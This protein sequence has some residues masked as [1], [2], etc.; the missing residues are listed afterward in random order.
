M[1]T[2][3]PLNVYVWSDGRRA[4]FPSPHPAPRLIIMKAG[5]SPCRF[6]IDVDTRAGGTLPPAL[7]W[8][9]KWQRTRSRDQA[10]VK[11]CTVRGA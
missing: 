3:V 7:F 4:G 10:I 5:S 11:D 2:D 1:R 8:P 6:R 9:E